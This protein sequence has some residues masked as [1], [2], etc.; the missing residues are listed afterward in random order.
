MEWCIDVPWDVPLA[1][2]RIVPQH[3]LR[4]VL[5]LPALHLLYC[6]NTIGPNPCR[7]LLP[8]S[9]RGDGPWPLLPL[10][11]CMLSDNLLRRSRWHALVNPD[12]L[13][14][15][16]LRHKALI[17]LCWHV[18][19]R[20][21]HW[22]NVLNFNRLHNQ[23]LFSLHLLNLPLVLKEEGLQLLLRLAWLFL[24]LLWL[25]L[26]DKCRLE[27]GYRWRLAHGFGLWLLGGLTLVRSYCWSY[28]FMIL[29]LHGKRLADLDVDLLLVLMSIR[30]LIVRISERVCMLLS[31]A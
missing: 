17:H 8:V 12:L 6:R 10:L 25:L 7:H 5:L 18:C 4:F 21:S 11:R 2:T 28:Y 15:L 19:F 29:S 16:L 20:K 1:S 27:A 22:Q 26:L 23:L 13:I 31:F 24:D 14:L 3:Q 9:M 30:Y